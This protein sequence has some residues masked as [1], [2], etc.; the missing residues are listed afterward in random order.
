MQKTVQSEADVFLV[1][2][3]RR[4]LWT[5]VVSV[6]GCVVVFCTTYALILPAITAEKTTC[7]LEEH[8]HTEECY[9]P[10]PEEPQTVLSC[11]AETL[12]IHS[13]TE[14]C[15]DG[16]GKLICGLA[17]YVAH[18]H[19]ENCYD[20]EGV[21]VCT[22]PEKPGHV[23]TEACYAPAEEGHVHTD[24]CYETQ[25]GELTCGL[26]ENKEHQHSADCYEQQKVLVCPLAAQSP[27]PPELICGQPETVTH[28][29]TE[30]CFKT[31][32]PVRELICQLP[33]HTHTEDCYEKLTAGDP[34]ADL[35]TAADWEAS[36]SGVVLTGDYRADLLAIAETQLG[37]R[38][39][40]RNF[41]IDEAGFVK[42]YTRYGEWYG[43][44]YGDWCA[45]FVSFCLHYAGIPETTVPYESGCANWVSALSAAGLYRSAGMAAPVKGDIIF[46]DND[47][48]GSADH[49][50]LVAGVT[51]DEPGIKTIEGNSAD[52]VQYLSYNSSASNILG[53]A[54]IPAAPDTQAEPE[55]DE[56]ADYSVALFAALL[57]GEDT[58]AEPITVDP[59]YI[60]G[61]SLYY[62]NSSE[63]DWIAVTEDIIIPGT[64]ELKLEVKYDKIPLRDLQSNGGLLQFTVPSLLRNPT[65]EGKITDD[66][67]ERIGT[68]AVAD[69]VLTIDFDETWL[70]KQA[71]KN[72]TL[73]YG[74]F[75]VTSQINYSEVGEG[76]KTELVLGEVVLKAHFEEDIVAKNGT[77]TLTKSVAP[78]IIESADGD[79]AEYTLTITAGEDGC[80]QVR[81][82]DHFS[83]NGEYASYLGVSQTAKTLT[84]SGSPGETVP[85]GKAHGTIAL[86]EA[87]DLVWQIGDMAP[88][89]T[90][91]LRYRVKLEEGYTYIQNSD[92]KLISNEA[93]SYA[94]SYPKDKA[95]ADLEPKAG[96]NLQKTAA[97]PVRNEDGSYTITYTLVAE[98]NRSN[99]FTLKNVSISDLLNDPEKSTNEACLPDIQYV[100]GSFQ[101]YAGN[102][103]SG[104]ATAFSPQMNADGK[105]FTAVLGDLAPGEAYCIQYQVHVGLEALAAAGGEK[106]LINNTVKAFSD[107]AKLEDFDYLGTKQQ[108]KYLQ[109]SHWAKKLVGDPIAADT[110]VP[111]SGSIF[112]AT[113]TEL[114]QESN[115]PESFTAPSGSYLYTVVVNELGDWD[116]TSASM[117]DRINGAYM[118]FVGYVKVEALDTENGNSVVNTLWVKV[119]GNTSFNFTMAQLGLTG[120]QYAYRLSYYAQPK[121]IEGTA[122][123]IVKNSFTLSGTIIPGTGDPFVLTGV[124]A[125]K[126]VILKGGDNLNVSKSAWYYEGPSSSVGNYSNGAL[127]WAIKI[128]GDAIKPGFHVQ[129]YITRQSAMYFRTDSLIGVF[130]G[131][132]D[133]DISKYSD[134]QS[135]LNLG[136]LSEVDPEYYSYEYSNS[137]NLTNGFS[138]LTIKFEHTIPLNNDSLYIF[139][140]LSP[141]FIPSESWYYYNFYKTSDDGV[142]WGAAKNAFK[143]LY[144]GTNIWK[145][146]GAVFKYNGE[147]IQETTSGSTGTIVTSELGE[148]GMFVSWDITVNYAGDLSGRYRLVDTLPDGMELAYVRLQQRGNNAKSAGV[149]Q[150][151]DLSADFTAYSTTAKPQGES[152]EITTWYY[153][154]GDTIVWDVNNLEAGKAVNSYAVTFQVVCRVTD[155]NILLGGETK[156]FKNQI[157]LYG[158]DGRQRDIDTQTVSVTTETLKKAVEQGGRTLPF[159]I[160]VNSL[161]EDLLEGA[162]KLTVVD[163]LS[164]TLQ[165]DPTSITVTNS[166]TQATVPFTAS[167]DGNTLRIT[168][169]DN[170]PLT[171][172]YKAKVLAKPGES[173]SIKNSAHWEGY[174]VTG[175]GSIEIKNYAYSVGGTAG[176]SATPYVEIVK[177]D[178]GSVNTRLAGAEFEMAEG[179]MENGV[180]TP[181]AGK[182]WTGT[183]DA[184][185][186]LKFGEGQLM[187]YNTVYRIT[188]TKAP[189][190]FVLDSTPI[191]FLVAKANSEG[192]YP[193]YPDGVDIW[194]ESDTYECRVGN[195]RGTASVT[196]QFEDLGQPVE[197]ISGT[198]RFGLYDTENPAGEPMQTATLAFTTGQTSQNTAKFS[199]L[200]LGKTYYIYELDDDGKPVRNGEAALVGGNQFAVTYPDGSAV[201]IA[202]DGSSL[203]VTVTN[204]VSYPELPETGG[205][206]TKLYTMGGLLLIAAA[207]LLL[208]YNHTRRRKEDSASS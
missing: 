193:T 100:D 162:D 49:V 106:V 97:N 176:G 69:N 202:N 107:N 38:E 135:V 165:L 32:E 82:V 138:E 136:N 191:Y 2:K 3:R 140:K 98:A 80:P 56:A 196:K 175:G 133:N 188:E 115:P 197:P 70:Q 157:T 10:L 54:E 20:A 55:A 7:G 15:Y 141:A 11:T 127:Y 167:I 63:E 132:L 128:D 153:T 8:T 86:N 52:R 166:K 26:E 21:L 12:G 60:T 110:S 61:A 168:I 67:G 59:Y 42:G 186:M 134:V 177:Y 147:T 44:P 25:Q 131:T 148:P 51:E 145:K 39:S 171:I 27:V 53:Y 33:E 6:L 93:Q 200:E 24:A 90:R 194:Y 201:T 203:A 66:E 1:K 178:S 71:D 30:S 102:R 34:S 144:E 99:M 29:H 181:T 159:T 105:G 68:A 62:R 89:E 183:T 156:E 96:L 43:I 108:E 77:V 149:A 190:G 28:Q 161:G 137:L 142:S 207:S 74:S 195:G 47:G 180:F 65:A 91:T 206:G 45:M 92:S 14:S 173:T 16:E 204:S 155:P 150:I 118:Q 139:V 73:I 164:D 184:Q 129:D 130:I 35:E 160:T 85:T 179:T 152:A 182:T 185:G 95:T 112:D 23:H 122:A 189:E 88:N 103:A 116:V 121:T 101:Y 158:E 117:T 18:T 37:Y 75:Y 151:N 64:A 146:V 205:A 109:Y 84:S 104:T 4:R 124:T 40:T 5:K 114:V 169:P 81:V 9:A 119:D 120:N 187:A 172:S 170:L 22:L 79:Y 41:I 36:L 48:D 50:G 174:E 72:I 31:V 126:D 113:G 19:D 125:S 123:V 87:G 57:S 17:D 58:T 76:G 154:D 198:Y 78:K 143:I 208:L 163:T 111:I 83:A 192:N 46:F 199:D 94:G 13:H